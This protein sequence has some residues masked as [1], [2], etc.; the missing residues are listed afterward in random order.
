M[1]KMNINKAN[2]PFHNWNVAC[3]VELAEKSEALKR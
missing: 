3:F 1:E 2:T